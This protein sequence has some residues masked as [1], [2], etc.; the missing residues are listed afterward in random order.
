MT[1]E[2][3]CNWM[4]KKL[5]KRIQT[6]NKM[7]EEDCQTISIYESRKGEFD[8]FKSKQYDDAK[9]RLFNTERKVGIQKFKLEKIKKK[10]ELLER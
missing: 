6:G 2:L 9:N 5:E 10:L 8:I 1:E 3:Y 7:M 4:V